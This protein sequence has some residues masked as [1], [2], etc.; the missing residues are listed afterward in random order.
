VALVAL[1]W[2]RRD[3]AGDVEELPPRA[4]AAPDAADRA[5]AARYLAD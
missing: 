4:D 2:P 3:V 1:A 5:V